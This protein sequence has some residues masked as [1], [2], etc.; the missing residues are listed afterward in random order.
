AGRI[1]DIRVL[2]HVIIAGDD[3]TSF[4]ERGLI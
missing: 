1:V 3:Y 4:V 2:D